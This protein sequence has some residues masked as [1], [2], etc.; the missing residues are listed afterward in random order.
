MHSSSFS[1]F[2]LPL[3]LCGAGLSAGN[4]ALPLCFSVRT[5]LC[6]SPGVD[7]SSSLGGR[8]VN[9]AGKRWE[10]E[11]RELELKDEREEV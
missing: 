2:S 7:G 5:V 9:D 11:S 1:L 8:V 10:E 3:R 4:L 6:L